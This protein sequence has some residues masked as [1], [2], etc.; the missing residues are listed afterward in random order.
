MLAHQVLHTFDIGLAT[1]CAKQWIVVPNMAW[2]AK[3]LP[4]ALQETSEGST[5]I[6]HP[7]NTGHGR[8]V[9]K[10]A[11]KGRTAN[12]TISADKQTRYKEGEE[13]YL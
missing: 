1:F 5:S 8:G 13:G 9:G 11:Q 12:Q 4:L 6:I 7:W 10:M 2:S 3:N